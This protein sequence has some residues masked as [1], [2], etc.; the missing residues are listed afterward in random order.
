[1]GPAS[2]TG[3]DVHLE[4]TQLFLRCVF[5]VGREAFAKLFAPESRMFQIIITK[6][7][8]GPLTFVG[9]TTAFDVYDSISP[10]CCFNTSPPGKHTSIHLLRRNHLFSHLAQVLVGGCSYAE[11][12]TACHQQKTP[13]LPPGSF[14]RYEHLTHMFRTPEISMRSS[15]R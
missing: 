13:V 12:A 6:T 11:G 14:E 15:K 3:Y 4:T 8:Y 7:T 1:M 5:R 10:T 2:R 9:S